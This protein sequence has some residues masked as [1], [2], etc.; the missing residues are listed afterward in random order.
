MSRFDECIRAAVDEGTIGD[1]EAEA[2]RGVWERHKARRRA[3]GL[4]GESAD[5]EAARDAFADLERLRARQAKLDRLNAEKAK[6]ISAEMRSFRNGSGE[7]DVLEYLQAKIEYLGQGTG[8]KSSVE[9]RRKAI[10]GQAHAHMESVLWTFRKGFLGRRV[11]KADLRNVVRE[12]FGE[13]TGDEAAKGFARAWRETAEMLRERFNRAGGDI[14]QLENWGL[15]QAH[16]ARAIRKFIR[17]NGRPALIA[18]LRESLDVGKMKDR[19]GRPFTEDT[20]EEA[21]NAVIDNI[22]TDGWISREASRQPFGRGALANQRQ[23]ERFLI[24]R[25]PDTWLAWQEDFGMGGPFNAMMGHISMMARD[26]AAMEVLGPNPQATLTWLEQ[27][28]QQEAAKRDLGR[29]GLLPERFKPGSGEQEARKK[30]RRAQLMW[31]HYTGRVNM[32]VHEGWADALA[33]ARNVITASTLGSAALSAMPTDPV[34]AGMAR[35][36]AGT[37]HARALQQ[38]VSRFSAKSRREAVQMGLVMETALDVLG[39][40]A[41]YAG[42][43]SGKAWS[44]FLAEQVLEVSALSPWTRAGRA[45]FM[46][47]ALFDFGNVSGRAFEDLDGPL[48]TTLKRYGFEPEDWERM[49]KSELTEDGAINPMALD[50]DLRNRLLELVNQESEYAVPSGTLR[51]R[52]LLL[53]DSRPGTIIGEFARSAAMFMSFGATIPVL[54]GYRIAQMV[55]SGQTARGAGYA[56]GL[57]LTASLGGALALQL[58]SLAAGRDPRDMTDQDFWAAAALQGGGVGIWGD[59][60][61]ADVNRFGGSMPMTAGGPLVELADNLRNLTIGNAI[62]AAQ[63]KETKFFKELAALG[64]RYTPGTNIWYL[65][66][67]WERTA[68]DRLMELADPEAAAAFR[69][70]EAYYRRNFGQEYWWAP[71]DPSPERGPDLAAAVG[72]GP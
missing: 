62:E 35:A 52:S 64:G 19:D 63:G 48:Q 21:L 55:R 68:E 59:F 53:G 23:E 7:L 31:G 29:G 34:F 58:K 12:A 37:G 15:P 17:D 72:E 54:W 1:A 67:A 4:K 13:D 51:S 16:N 57:F 2:L 56:L 69:R 36:F 30:I 46:M 8:L 32:P 50:M 70:R 3:E 18:R 66:L 43:F 14:G 47:G 65:R 6:E 44:M 33:N 61:F 71:G 22:L 25:D 11:N 49:R 27:I 60:L 20:L 40:Q 24:F 5:A 28:A 42:Q 38:Q 45:G 39:E 9:G 10:I 41:R 26:I